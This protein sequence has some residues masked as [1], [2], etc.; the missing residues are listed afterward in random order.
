V[1]I[2]VEGSEIVPTGY[3]L[4]LAVLNLYVLV[5]DS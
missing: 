3:G 1:W 4:V 2:L 5:L